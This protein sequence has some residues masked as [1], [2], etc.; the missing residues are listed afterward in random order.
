MLYRLK[1][2]LQRSGV[3]VL[4]RIAHG[5]AIMIGQVTIGDPVVIHPGLYLLHGQVVI[6]GVVEIHPGVVIGPFVTLGL[7]SGDIAGPTIHRDVTI[8]TGARLIGGI[9]VGEGA[10]VGANAVV[11]DDVP[12][13]ATV[14]GAPARPTATRASATY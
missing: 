13:G 2:R 1:A 12:A 4:P 3:P 14:V 7:R 11:V 8:G 10:S 9:H 5:L 6:D